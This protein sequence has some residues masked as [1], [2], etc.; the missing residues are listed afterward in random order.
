[1]SSLVE[2]G[3]GT[4]QWGLPYG[5]ANTGGRP[6]CNEVRS[7]LAEARLNG[8][9]FLDTAHHYGEAESVLGD[10]GLEDFRIV[11]KTPSFQ[12]AS[13]SVM[14][15]EELSDAFRQSLRRLS[16]DRIYGLLLHRV[17]DLLVP[18]GEILLNTMETLKAQGLISK[19]GVSV[20]EGYQIDA[21]LRLFRPDI[22]QLPLNVFDQRLIHSGHVNLLREIGVEIHARSVF[23]QGLLL[24]PL[25]RLPAFFEPVYELLSQ[26]HTVV[27]D[28]G[29]SPTQAAMAY[30]RD[31]PGVKTMLIGV[32]TVDQF[33]TCLADFSSAPL[34]D[35]SGLGCDDARY[36]NPMNWKLN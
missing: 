19:I 21:V 15:A 8:V 11:T 24:M 12:T 30:V 22:I 20:Y 16:C 34:F 17:E 1:M 2:L 4:A 36:L 13:I 23:L 26:W 3:L 18:G 9:R 10:N 7:I 28:R 33:K 25:D 32:D 29:L 31:C 35:A 14:Q 6:H 27:S 5:I